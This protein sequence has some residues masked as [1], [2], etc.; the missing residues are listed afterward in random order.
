MKRIP[1]L[2]LLAF[3]AAILVAPSAQARTEHYDRVIQKAFGASDL[4]RVLIQSE[5]LRVEGYDGDS[6]EVRAEFH[7]AISGWYWGGSEFHDVEVRKSGQ[8]LV[9]TEIDKHDG[10]LGIIVTRTTD[11]RFVV[12]VPKQ[13][14]VEVHGE[15]GHILLHDLQ[16]SIRVEFEDGHLEIRDT[17]SPNLRVHF[18]D[19]STKLYDFQGALEVEFVDGSL[20]VQDSNLSALRLRYS[21]GRAEFEAGIGREGPYDVSLDDGRF[22]WTFPCSTAATFEARVEDGS[23]RADFPGLDTESYRRFFDHTLGGGGP[24]VEIDAQ[25]G[26]IILETALEI[27]RQAE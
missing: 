20:R 12:R 14:A 17:S 24:L 27:K 15:D 2:L 11:N 4:S 26:S 25:D 1:V 19:G 10:I 7:V 21:D 8:T 13:L 5:N 18:E 6:V 9:I 22:E 3:C 23:I 16:S